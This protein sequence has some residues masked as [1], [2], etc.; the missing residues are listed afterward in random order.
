M[1]HGYSR[2][3]EFALC[4]VFDLGQDSGSVKVKNVPPAGLEV[5]AILPPRLCLYSSTQQCLPIWQKVNLQGLPSTIYDRPQWQK[6]Q[7]EPMLT[8]LLMLF[9]TANQKKDRQFDSAESTANSRHLS[10]GDSRPL[11]RGVLW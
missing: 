11:L 1:V 2:E 7:I 3:N 6:E 4:A 8:L 9:A 5:N 10:M